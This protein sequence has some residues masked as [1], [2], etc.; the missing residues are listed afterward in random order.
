VFDMIT[1]ATHIFEDEAF[2]ARFSQFRLHVGPEFRTAVLDLWADSSDEA[3]ISHT[4]LQ[5]ASALIAQDR[6]EGH[7]SVEGSCETGF[8]SSAPLNLF[9]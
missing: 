3:L 7:A 9:R 8:R 2:A 1:H 4:D 5:P 6:Q